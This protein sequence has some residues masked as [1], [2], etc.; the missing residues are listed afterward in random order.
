MIRTV[1]INKSLAEKL[2]CKQERLIG[3]PC[4]KFICRADSPPSAC[5]HAQMLND[6]N[7]HLAETY[8][9]HLGMNL[10]ITSSS[11]YDD[12]G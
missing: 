1:R 5:P 2:K 3:E 8:N 6:G 9:R 10:L 11:L 4:Y 12:Q 7:E